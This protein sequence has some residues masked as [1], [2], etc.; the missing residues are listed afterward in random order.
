MRKKCRQLRKHRAIKDI[1][2]IECTLG[3]KSE[4][5]FPWLQI[6]GTKDDCAAFVL[7]SVITKNCKNAES[8]SDNFLILTHTHAVKLNTVNSYDEMLYIDDKGL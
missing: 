4:I 3:F 6:C 8:S 1:F 7:L 2:F 5:A